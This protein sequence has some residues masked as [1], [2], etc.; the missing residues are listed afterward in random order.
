[1]FIEYI[2]Q[3]W[4]L[5]L[6]LLAFVI[7]LVTTVFIDK[8]RRIRMYILIGAVF[9]LSIVV[10]IEFSI[11]K[12]ITELRP[13]RVAMMAIRYSATP[14][15][16]A[17]VT[18]A[19]V[20]R[21]RW[22]VFIPA[23]LQLIL[24]V[25][26]IWTGIVFSVNEANE[27]VRFPVLGYT[28]F[29]MVGL[30][31]I[32]LIYLLIKHSNKSPMEIVYMSCFA[33]GLASGVA[34]PFILKDGYAPMFCSIIAVSLFA[35]FEFCVLQ[36]TKK[37]ALT[38]LLNRHA[39]FADINNDPKNITAI[40]SIDMNGLKLLN[41]TVGHAAGDEALVTL[42]LCFMKALRNK[43]S[44]YRIGGDEFL[45]VCRKTPK[46]EVIRIVDEIRQSV[47]ETEYS[48]S[49][50]YSFN[51]EGNKPINDLLKESDEMM[52]KEKEKYYQESGEQR[53]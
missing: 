9:L 22:F 50:G 39:Y 12:D 51:L 19:M 4:P 48:C 11:A 24:N 17:L 34:L 25:V 3:N 42:S 45:I 13:L 15:I 8:K 2:T 6:I 14:L 7:S 20:K 41:D 18:F 53:R 21:M 36:L 40:I 38:G 35:Y 43:Q 44:G 49:I 29:V 33:F 5:I 52:Y 28:P 27:L 16:L 46:E 26:S 23:L 37:D 47:S 30:Y 1:M 31:S 10:F 32:L